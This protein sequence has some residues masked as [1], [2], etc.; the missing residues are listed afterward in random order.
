MSYRYL[1]RS[2]LKV[3]RLALGTMMFG[4]PTDEPTPRD[5]RAG[6]GGASTSSTPPTSTRRAAPRKSW[7]APSGTTATTGCWPPVRQPAGRG[8]T[9]RGTSR[10][11]IIQAVEGS[12]R[13]LGTD[14]LDI[15]YFHR[16]DFNAPL[17]E[18]VR[19]IGDL[20]RAGK[21]RYFG[22]SNFRG[23]RIAEAAHLADA[24]GID[25][26]VASQPLYNLVNRSAEAEQLP[27][28][29]AYGVGVVSYSPLARGVLT[30]KYEPDQ[31]PAAGARA[32]ARTGD[33]WKRVASESLRIARR[34]RDYL[35]TKGIDPV[36]FALGWVLNNR[37]VTS[38]IAGPRTIEQWESYANALDYAFTAEDEALVDSLVA[39]GHPSTPASP[40]PDTRWKAAC[41][42]P[43]RPHA[44][45]RRNDSMT[46]TSTIDRPSASAQDRTP[47]RPAWRRDDILASLPGQAEALLAGAVARER[48]RRLPFDAFDAVRASGLGALLVPVEH[49]G[50]D[51]TLE[52]VAEAIITL[53]AADSNVPHALRL[54]YNVSALWRVLPADEHVRQQFGRIL[55]G[56]LFGGASTEQG[57]PKPGLITTRL[58]RQDGHYRLNGR[59]Y[60]STGTLYADY[61]Y[62]AAIDEQD[63]PVTVILPLD[64]R[65]W[66]SSMT[67]TAS[68]SA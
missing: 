64:R 10:K 60:Y 33:C 56:K 48:E 4:G 6:Q 29:A 22:V 49:G 46:A 42:T 61:A 67:G 24:E 8:P 13:R 39:A 65:A 25:R 11:W 53:A 21:L 9:D 47:G 66:R 54:H 17:G 1:G 59:K 7:A 45:Q 35:D 18:A 20:I 40:I 57:T 19:A 15:L 30:A 14:Y 36:Q 28:A 32:R 68:A 55:A 63:Q 23:W 50:P 3:S 31:P 12:L 52:D 26:P 43:H 2:G 41:L 51:G 34:I 37:L 38:A 5:H 16:A 62:I 58:T 27:A 44:P